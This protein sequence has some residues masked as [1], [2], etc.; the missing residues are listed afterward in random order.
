MINLVC[1]FHNYNPS[2]QTSN[3]SEGFYIIVAALIASIFTL[4]TLWIRSAIISK[5]EKRKRTI[6]II[7][8]AARIM[9][10]Q[11][12]YAKQFHAR[13]NG[14][15]FYLQAHNLTGVNK[16]ITVEIKDMKSDY[17][18]EY[19]DSKKVAREYIYKMTEAR[20]EYRK[21]LTL[22]DII[23]GFNEIIKVKIDEMDNYKYTEIES[24]KSSKTIKQ[25]KVTSKKSLNKLLEEVKNYM[26]ILIEINNQMKKIAIK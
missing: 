8:D 12:E 24:F 7:A 26:E 16:K 5:E 1:H 18:L 3:L 15:R 14:A 19:I 23:Y 25:L 17:Y 11:G 2:V 10:Q 20:S 4:I 21:V 22:F 6:E 13:S 9:Q